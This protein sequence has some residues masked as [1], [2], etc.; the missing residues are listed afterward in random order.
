MTDKRILILRTTDILST[1]TNSTYYGQTI[2]NQ[3]GTISNNRDNMTW[4][5]INMR[6]LLGSMYDKYERFNISLVSAYIGVAEDAWMASALQPT[7]A[8]ENIRNLVIKLGGLPFDAPVWSQKKGQTQLAPVGTILLNRLH[9]SEIIKGCG[10]PALQQYPQEAN[11]Y[12]FTKSC[13]ISSI[14]IQ[15]HNV[16]TDTF[17]I[18][19]LYGAP[20][21]PRLHG[22]CIF[23]FSIEG[24]TNGTPE[25]RVLRLSTTDITTKNNT[26]DYV[27]AANGT[28][29]ANQYGTIGRN[30]MTTTWN[31]INIRATFGD[32]FYRRYKKYKINLNTCFVTPQ[33]SASD[34]I[35]NDSRQWSKFPLANATQTTAN[36][37]MTDSFRPVVNKV[38]DMKVITSG[39]GTVS[40]QEIMNNIFNVNT[41]MGIG[42]FPDPYFYPIDGKTRNFKNLV[43]LK[44]GASG[45]QNNMDFNDFIDGTTII[46]FDTNNYAPAGWR[47]NGQVYPISYESPEQMEIFFTAKP[48]VSAFPTGYTQVKLGRCY[49]NPTDPASWSWSS[50]TTP[51][52]ATGAWKLWFVDTANQYVALVNGDSTSANR[53]VYIYDNYN[54]TG[55]PTIINLSG[56]NDVGLRTLLYTFRKPYAILAPQQYQSDGKAFLL[57]YVGSGQITWTITDAYLSTLVSAT[58]TQV[59]AGGYVDAILTKIGTG[60]SICFFAPVYAFVAAGSAFIERKIIVWDGVQGSTPEFQLIGAVSSGTAGTLN[61][62]SNPAIFGINRLGANSYEVSVCDFYGDGTRD[63]IA[64]VIRGYDES[65]NTRTYSSGAAVGT[66]TITF[67]S[68]APSLTA[69]Q[70]PTIKG[71][72]LPAGTYITAVAGA[73]ATLSANFTV[74]G[75]GDYF[76]S[77]AFGANTAAFDNGAIATYS[78]ITMIGQSDSILMRLID[79]TFNTTNFVAQV[80]FGTVTIA[81]TTLPSENKDLSICLD[82]LAYSAPTYSTP[83]FIS[84]PTALMRTITLPN[85]SNDLYNAGVDGQLNAVFDKPVPYTFQKWNEN[86]PLT[87][88]LYDIT[89]ANGLAGTQGTAFPDYDQYCAKPGDQYYLFDVEG[90]EEEEI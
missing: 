88:N 78:R 70:L 63:V 16:Q 82:G 52:F 75:S 43:Y 79:G 74:Q 77:N 48:A 12:T 36:S 81:S 56:S 45:S 29:D 89:D 30:K 39:G 10:K 9:D 55:T 22:H 76:I 32:E 38:S 46:N 66:N 2:R 72:G 3:N 42:D 26:L 54:L 13:D 86:I 20:T 40:I 69:G 68:A 41:D 85:Y 80:N 34:V 44:S 33:D 84:G 23:M 6:Q 61:R 28:L 64:A 24:V 57:N 27:A 47:F 62:G 5:N 50:G 21:A 31:N 17:P 11:Q 4:N 59:V 60:Y 25:R 1:N 58:T 49:G 37:Y 51:S 65:A 67:T 87:I 8:V 7:Q 35:S 19:E 83:Q 15:L 90:V 73:T 53:S 71:T 14:N 18:Y